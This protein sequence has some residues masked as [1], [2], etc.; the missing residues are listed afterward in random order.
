MFDESY[1]TNYAE[2]L[3]AQTSGPFIILVV[4]A[5][6]G[7]LGS[8][9]LPC[10]LSLLPMN[11]A[12]IGTLDIK[13][14]V[15]ALSKASQ[16]VLGVASIITL[17][18]V[19]ASFAGAVFTSYKAELHLAIGVIVTLMAFSLFDLIKL[20]LPQ[21]FKKIPEVSPF[22]V[23]VI[24]ALVSSPCSSPVLITALS[25]SV[26][27]GSTLK[28]LIFMFSFSLGYTAII[29]F[30]SLSTGLVKQLN[31]FKVNSA[32]ITKISASLML[33]MGLFYLYSG[34]TKLG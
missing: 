19:F 29:F 22:L 33:I 9:L 28:S 1:L 13:D 10:V 34:I 20:P 12:Y 27:F 8:S 16:F 6:L 24:F 11:L 7:G 18:G 17:L 23:G 15:A 30:A 21:F 2:F 5:F 32:L 26:D 31:W 25:V 3:E 14:K 4:L